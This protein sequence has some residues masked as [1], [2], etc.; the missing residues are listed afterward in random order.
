MSPGS[1][2]FAKLEMD[3]IRPCK[4]CGGCQIRVP[5]S[6]N[7]RQSR[8]Q[9]VLGVRSLRLIY[10]HRFFSPIRRFHHMCTSAPYPLNP[11]YFHKCHYGNYL[12]RAVH[13]G[14]IEL[15]VACPTC[16]F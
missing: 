15:I 16:N 6:I 7:S 10:T 4:T 14:S 2:S 3:A 1:L 8:L 13:L 9:S 11:H 12:L 5:R